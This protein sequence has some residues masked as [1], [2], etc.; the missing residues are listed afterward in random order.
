MHFQKDLHNQSLTV[1]ANQFLVQWQR[2][3]HFCK[4]LTL[5]YR[6]LFVTAILS[7]PW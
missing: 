6:L 5:F 2:V 3:L 4:L 1:F 7:V